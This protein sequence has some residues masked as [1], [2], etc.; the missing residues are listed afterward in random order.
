M[1]QARRV[2]GIVDSHSRFGPA[3]RQPVV[4]APCSFSTSLQGQGQG[5]GLRTWFLNLVPSCLPMCAIG[6]DNDL[7][8]RQLRRIETW[9]RLGAGFGFDLLDMPMPMEHP[10]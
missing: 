8:E 4:A 6:S 1:T 2:S 3:C 5:H 9:C 7:S 10:E